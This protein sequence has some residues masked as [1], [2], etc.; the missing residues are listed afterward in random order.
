MAATGNPSVQGAWEWPQW[1]NSTSKGANIVNATSIGVVD[2]SRCGF[3]DTIDNTYLNFTDASANTSSTN[4]TNGTGSGTGSKTGNGAE[5]RAVIGL[6]GLVI[7]V[8][9]SVSIL[10][11]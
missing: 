5:S 11:G 8:G 7:A 6:W 1:D 9:V 10:I 3:W 2:Y 4:T